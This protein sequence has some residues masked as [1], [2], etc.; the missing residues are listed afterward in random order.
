MKNKTCDKSMTFDDC[1]L[2]ILRT[3]VDKAQK[4]IGKRIISSPE[5]KKII[6]IVEEYIKKKKFICYGGTAINNILPKEDQ[7]Y[8]KEAEIPDYDFFSYNA[9]E[10]AKELADI[11]VQHGFTDVEAKSGQHYGTYKVFVNY[12][13]VADLTNIPK[14]IFSRLKMDAILKN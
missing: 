8:D 14:E 1:V 7:F 9:I 4:K 2:I 10:D 13:P 5:I 3:A 11:Y 12:I 6:S